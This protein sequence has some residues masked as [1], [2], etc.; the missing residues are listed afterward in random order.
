MVVRQ[1]ASKSKEAIMATN[2]SLPNVPEAHIRVP[3][4]SKSSSN[5][6]INIALVLTV[7]LSLACIIWAA[8]AVPKS[9]FDGAQTR[10]EMIRQNSS[11][12]DPRTLPP[13]TTG[14]LMPNRGDEHADGNKSY[15]NGQEVQ[16]D[17]ITRGPGS[18]PAQPE[19][20]SS[21]AGQ[22]ETGGVTSN[23]GQQ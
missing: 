17:T 13:G 4:E 19:K 21:R 20:T 22:D 2:S 14:A 1:F 15:L 23:S 12:P 18:P 7:V 16:G 5:R 8:L 10:P 9:N 3:D 11:L 6:G